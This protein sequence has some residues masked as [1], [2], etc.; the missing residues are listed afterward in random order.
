MPAYHDQDRM[1]GY[2]FL[3]CFY[4]VFL[5]IL[6]SASAVWLIQLMSGLISC[7]EKERQK[8]AGMDRRK[9][10]NRRESNSVQVGK[11]KGITAKRETCNVR[12][13][14]LNTQNPSANTRA[15][16]KKKT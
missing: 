1:E 14:G 13:I 12:E 7:D 4:S 16:V 15:S 11:N 9:G 8:N 3:T 6:N 10:N 2:K 5:L